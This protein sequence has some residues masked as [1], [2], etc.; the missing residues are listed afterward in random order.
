MAED[1]ISVKCD[2]DLFSELIAPTLNWRPYEYS[3]EYDMDTGKRA[4]TLTLTRKNAEEFFESWKEAYDFL[5]E[6]KGELYI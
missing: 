4:G 6:L 5:T 2:G 1:K 3:N